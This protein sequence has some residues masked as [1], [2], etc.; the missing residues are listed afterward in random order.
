[1]LVDVDI[2][3]EVDGVVSYLPKGFYGRAIPGK[4]EAL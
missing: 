2:F 3:Q 4:E 1:M